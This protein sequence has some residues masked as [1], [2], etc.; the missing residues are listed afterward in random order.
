VRADIFVVVRLLADDRDVDDA[1][2][3]GQRSGPQLGQ[4][5]ARGAQ[6]GEP[7]LE[8]SRMHLAVGVDEIGARQPGDGG[9]QRHGEHRGGVGGQAGREAGVDDDHAAFR[10]LSGHRAAG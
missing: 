1:D 4:L 3:G 7:L 2:P 8:Q 9:A 10:A 5:L 6:H